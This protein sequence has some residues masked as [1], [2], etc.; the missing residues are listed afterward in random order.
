MVGH[1]NERMGSRTTD[2]RHSW[3]GWSGHAITF[4]LCDREAEAKLHYDMENEVWVQVRRNGIKLGV[5]RIHGYL[6]SSEV[7]QNWLLPS[8]RPEH[9]AAVAG[10]AAATI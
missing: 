2:L 4:W 5:R 3:S 6:P 8:R 10:S 1:Q 9:L 7:L